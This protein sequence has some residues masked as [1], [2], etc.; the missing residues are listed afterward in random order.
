MLKARLIRLTFQT[1]ALSVFHSW[2][3]AST[4]FLGFD[5]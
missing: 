4:Q 5:G 3:W 2:S 1:N